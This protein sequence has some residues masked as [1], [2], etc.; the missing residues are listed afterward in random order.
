MAE[1]AESGRST[2]ANRSSSLDPKLKARLLA[3]ARSPWRGLRRGLWLALFASAGV[4]L[5]TMTMRGL[6]GA[7]VSPADWLIQVVAFSVFGSLLW[8]DRQSQSL[9]G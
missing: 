1:S 5:T 4:G 6:S 3:E 8:F 9:D 2:G 7:P